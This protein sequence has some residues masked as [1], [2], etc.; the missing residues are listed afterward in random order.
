MPTS[1]SKYLGIP[2]ATLDS[3]GVF[4]PILDHDTLMELAGVSTES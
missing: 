2:K 1:L 3:L 4:D